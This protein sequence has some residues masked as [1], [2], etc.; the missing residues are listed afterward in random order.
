MHYV[1]LWRYGDPHIVFPKGRPPKIDPDLRFDAKWTLNPTTGCHIWNGAKRGT[2]HGV[3]WLDG[4]NI[5]AHVYAYQRKHGAVPG[6][7]VLDHFVCDNPPCCNPDHVRPA[8][9]RENILRGTSPSAH[10]ARKTHC[11]AGHEYTAANTYL[12]PKGGF[13]QCRECK[14]RQSYGQHRRRN[15]DAPRRGPYQRRNR[16]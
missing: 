15:P 4:R 2:G 10:N 13:R 12:T 3:F 7:L 14:R 1:R 8:T 11:P 6:S 9:D 5:G 16:D